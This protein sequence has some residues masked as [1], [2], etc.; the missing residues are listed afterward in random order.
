LGMAA[1]ISEKVRNNDQHFFKKFTHAR[2]RLEKFMIKNKSLVTLA[3]TNMSRTQR[4]AKMKD[5]FSFLVQEA[6]EDKEL[7][8]EAA[9]AQ[10]GLRG[11]ILQVSTPYSSKGPLKKLSAVHCVVV[12]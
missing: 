8:A 6:Y 12:F 3:L 5:L 10:L 2:E 4:T 7:T 11:H 9:V 1:L